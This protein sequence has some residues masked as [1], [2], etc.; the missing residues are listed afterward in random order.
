MLVGPTRLLGGWI[1]L[2]GSDAGPL[3]FINANMGNI[4]VF[5]ADGMFVRTLFHDSRTGKPWA[6]PRA[7]RGM[8]LNDVTLHDENFWPTVAQTPAGEVF[9]QDGGRSSLVRVEGLETLRRL[10][11]QTLHIGQQELQ[12]AVEWRMQAESE[13]QREQGN[14]MLTVEIRTKAPTVDGKLDDWSSAQFATID[15]RGTKANFNSNS[16]PYDVSAALA[17]AEG[18]LFAAFRTGDKDLLKNSGEQPLAP[19]KTGGALDLML[20][21]DPNADPKRTRPAP[22]D[23]RLLVTLITDP[24]GKVPPRRRALLYRAAVPGTAPKDRVPFSSPWRTIYF[25][26]V[27]DV[28]DQVTLAGQ[29]GDYEF[30]IPLETLGLKIAPGLKLK[31]DLGVLRGGAFQTHYRVYWTNKATAITADVPSE[32]ELLPSLWGVFS[33]K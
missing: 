19:F 13:R 3:W 23:L 33:F 29:N 12:A 31:G 17:V 24:A 16:K 28:S 6:M 4:Y 9:L 20:A 7:E 8:L 2:K 18:R 5:T 14:A 25:D 10:P 27:D 26:R 1:E 32:A 15:R 22:G 11:A 21:T 30:S